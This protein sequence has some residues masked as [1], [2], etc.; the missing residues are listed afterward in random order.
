MKGEVR[1]VIALEVRGIA[2]KSAISFMTTLIP[3]LV[4]WNKKLPFIKHYFC[5]VQL[6]F[7]C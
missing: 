5:L 4:L 7:L 6:A 3:F 1:E 2:E